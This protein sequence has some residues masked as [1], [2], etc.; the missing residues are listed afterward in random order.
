MLRIAEEVAKA[1]GPMFSAYLPLG[2][3]LVN[4]RPRQQRERDFLTVQRSQ[5]CV[6]AA[7]ESARGAD[8]VQVLDNRCTAN[9]AEQSSKTPRVQIDKR[10]EGVQL[11]NDEDGLLLR[12]DE[13]ERFR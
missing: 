2:K 11:V 4:S 3:D 6:V 10:T 8:D 1:L 5:A 9:Y 13:R 7:L 12:S